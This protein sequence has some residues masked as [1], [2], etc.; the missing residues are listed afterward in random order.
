MAKIKNLLFNADMAKALYSGFKTET[1]RLKAEFE[2]GDI[3]RVRENHYLHCN[4][5]SVRYIGDFLQGDRN[6]WNNVPG[7]YMKNENARIYLQVTA[8]RRE[9]LCDITEYSA[10]HEGVEM[11]STGFFR[12]YL[13]PTAVCTTAKE[14]FA[15]LWDSI[16]ANPK[17][18]DKK[19]IPFNANVPVNVIEFKLLTRDGVLPVECMEALQNA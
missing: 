7:K 10:A 18:K 14:S 15:T 5:W 4:G 12:N 8:V 13:H 9:R 17:D 11:F 16:N 1:R 2:V 3:I 6:N 19:A